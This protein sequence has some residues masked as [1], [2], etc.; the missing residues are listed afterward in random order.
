MPRAGHTWRGRGTPLGAA[1][2]LISAALWAVT[3]LLLRG[4]VLKLGGATANTWRT[5][6]SALCFA[7][8]F[9]AFRHPRDLLGIPAQTLGVLLASVLLSMVIGDILQFTAIGRLGIALAMP[10]ASSSPL[11]TLLIAAAFLGEAIT[12]RSVGGAVLVVGGVILVAMPRRALA[13]DVR[14][15]QR[16]LTT[17]HWIGVGLA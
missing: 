5:A 13:D 15:Q 9:L 11:F 7:V 16:A 4:Q 10:I 17:N 2:A 3:N 1:A 8:V 12:S 6:F 14:A